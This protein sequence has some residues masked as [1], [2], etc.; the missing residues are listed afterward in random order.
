M[1]V[2]INNEL[3]EKCKKDIAKFCEWAEERY[4]VEDMDGVRGNWSIKKYL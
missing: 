1:S 4:I 2:T 3:S